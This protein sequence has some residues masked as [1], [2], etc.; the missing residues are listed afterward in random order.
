M[1]R[2]LFLFVLLLNAMVVN[3]QYV[4]EEANVR[5]SYTVQQLVDT[6][7]TLRMYDI[8]E[9]DRAIDFRER[10]PL[11]SREDLHAALKQ[12]E[13]KWTGEYKTIDEKVQIEKPLKGVAKLLSKLAGSSYNPEYIDSVYTNEVIVQESRNYLYGPFEKGE[14]YDSEPFK[15]GTFKIISINDE[16][17]PISKTKF[18]VADLNGNEYD[19]GLNDIK[20][21]SP[22]G[23]VTI[24]EKQKEDFLMGVKPAE[25]YTSWD[26][27]SDFGEWYMSIYNN[28]SLRPKLNE[29]KF[30]S[31]RTGEVVDGLQ[32]EFEDMRETI[33]NEVVVAEKAS[34]G[35]VKFPSP[36]T[37]GAYSRLNVDWIPSVEIDYLNALLAGLE[38]IK[39]ESVESPQIVT[40]IKR[41]IVTDKIS[42]K[43]EPGSYYLAAEMEDG[44][45]VA[46]GDLSIKEL[47]DIQ[48]AKDDMRHSDWNWY[49]YK[50]Y[51]ETV[52]IPQEQ[53][54]AEWE[55]QKA[56]NAKQ[57]AADLQKYTQKY[58][59]EIAEAIV[60][61]RVIPGMTLEIIT[62]EMGLSYKILNSST[63]IVGPGFMGE[64]LFD[65]YKCV[66]VGNKVKL[67]ENI[68]L[69]N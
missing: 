61:S 3:A 28:E 59:S 22:I 57:R 19:F 55:K 2:F 47:Q 18:T 62:E 45:K 13:L 68:M 44:N 53:R 21:F 7:S 58:G 69:N 43:G 9:M 23:Y 65:M 40:K 32:V 37:D 48:V 31:L 30:I 6:I 34:F 46:I 50:I 36:M 24:V 25:D 14:F 26:C 66:I 27:K 33:G 52:L 11:W 39:P 10:R 20:S 1:K 12:L 15:T 49:D 60:D 64:L 41:F 29:I 5:K 67:V 51:R 35:S 38:V 4:D 63:I 54:E 16:N 42:Y 8:I 17:K 56:I